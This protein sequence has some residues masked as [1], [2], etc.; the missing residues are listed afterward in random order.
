MRRWWLWVFL[1]ALVLRLATLDWSLLWYDE[2]YT[3]I[4]VQRPFFE[5]LKAI[6]GDTHPPLWYLIDWIMAHTF[7]A[8]PIALR[9][10]ATIFSSLAVLESYLLT[11]RLAGE[12]S[13]R[14][15]SGLLAVLP[16]QIYYGQEARMYSLLTLLV[17]LGARSVVDRRWSRL[18]L[19]AVLIIYTQNLGVVYAGL[20]S[21]WGLW[22]SRGRAFKHLGLAGLAYVP[23]LPTI[24]NQLH[25]YNIGFWLPPMGNIGGSLYWI[26][27]T[28]VFS[29]L[30]P[31]MAMHGIALAMATTVIACWALRSELKRIWPLLAIAFAPAAVL[32]VIGTVWRPV[33][34]DRAMLPSGAALGMVWGI[35]LTHL[36]SWGKKIYAAVAAPVLVLMV[37][38]YYVDPTEQRAR[39]DPVVELVK[40]NW[41]EGDAIYHI[42]LSSFIGY[43]YYLQGYPSYVLP[44]TGD[45]G[46]SLTETTKEGFGIT[47]HELPIGQVKARGHR[48]VWLFA[49]SSPVSSTY[50]LDTERALLTT[51]KTIKVWSIRH[52]DLVDFDVIL[53]EL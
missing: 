46:A 4:I 51:F 45:L 28:T 41:Q 6:A 33:L 11:K 43:D 44:E 8:T 32:T 19:C 52:K 2:A 9:L 50:E 30:P 42:S 16:G 36:P 13:A 12:N 23:W 5:M 31:W 39:V 24:L 21:L 3:A 14:W 48:R 47:E 20:L 35:G 29:R 17:L 7:G 25:N 18:G 38:L 40:A 26:S 1:F 53:L 34:L 15:A 27:F 22:E 37:V 49:S 10:P